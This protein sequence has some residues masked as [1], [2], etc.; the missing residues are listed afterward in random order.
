VFRFHIPCFI[1]YKCTNTRKRETLISANPAKKKTARNTGRS[2]TIIRCL[3]TFVPVISVIPVVTVT[4]VVT[5]VIASTPLIVS[6]VTAETI[7][8]DADLT[9]GINTDINVVSFQ[10]ERR[11]RYQSF[12]LAER[13]SVYLVNFDTVPSAADAGKIHGAS[14]VGEI[15]LSINDHLIFFAGL[16]RYYWPVVS[17]KNSYG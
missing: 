16:Q 14:I 9:K 15:A 17:S 6:P 3:E 10:L 13:A 11:G 7:F 4:T 1:E 5:M 8:C 2:E 12:D